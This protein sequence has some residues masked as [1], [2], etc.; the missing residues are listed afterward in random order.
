MKKLSALVFVLLFAVPASWG[1]ESD[2][3]KLFAEANRLYDSQNYLGAIQLYEQ[4][5]EKGLRTP[6]LYYNLAS[7]HFKTKAIG[8]SVLYLLRAEKLSPWDNDIEGNLRFVSQFTI[9]KGT[10]SSPP[11]AFFTELFPLGTWA[12]WAT[13]FYFLLVGLIAIRIWFKSRAVPLRIGT[14]VTGILLT[15]FAVGF[16]LSWSWSKVPKGVFLAKEAPVKSGPGDDFVT[17]LLG[18]EGLTFQILEERDNYFEV[19]LP[20]GVKG[21]V[22]KEEAAKV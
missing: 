9:D 17:Q 21:W 12:L 14:W 20:N 10:L 8:K 13:I 19:L 6:A 1:Q 3:K 5:A 16:Y 7:A 22:K 4:L 2:P 18:H 11:L 15:L